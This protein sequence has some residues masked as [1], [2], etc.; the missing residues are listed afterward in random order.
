MIRRLLSTFLDF[1]SSQLASEVF[2]Q[3][4]ASSTG[5]NVF[6]D[7]QLDNLNFLFEFSPCFPVNGKCVKVIK[8][9]SEF[10][11]TILNQATH[12]KSRISL[13]S[14]YLGV[15]KLETDLIKA[16]QTNVSRNPNLEINFLLDYTRGT[17]GVQN[18]KAIIMPLLQQSENCKLSLYHTPLLRGITKRIAPARWNE[19]LGIQHMKIYLFDDTVIISGANLSS[20]YCK[21]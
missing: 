3:H 10:Y 17:R 4:N 12:A 14:L 2:F 11:E 6:R 16:M 8:E 7:K 5:S 20:D 19:L 15:G 13:A 9:P 18:S 1:P 21:P